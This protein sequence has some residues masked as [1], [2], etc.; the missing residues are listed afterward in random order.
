MP[1]AWAECQWCHSKQ[2]SYFTEGELAQM[3]GGKPH[4]RMCG[5]CQV[6][7]QWSPVEPPAPPA[8]QPL[9]ATAIK[10]GMPTVLVIDDDE[11]ILAVLRKMLVNKEFHVDAADSARGAL[12]KMVNE[13]F[14]VIISDIHMPGFDGKK[15]F[16][17]IAEYMP[18]YRQRVMFLT[19]DTESTDTQEFLRQSGCPYAYKPINFDQLLGKV[20]ELLATQQ[21]PPAAPQTS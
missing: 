11:D 12:S 15:M 13:N 16:L 19:G 8:E 3:R 1:F 18:E 9:P 7:T 5:F 4:Y 6:P 10:L 17:F 21:P 2:R 14:D 20:N